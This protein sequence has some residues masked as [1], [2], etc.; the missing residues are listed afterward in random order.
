MINDLRQVRYTQRSSTIAGSDVYISPVSGKTTLS[1]T[2]ERHEVG[3]SFT[4]EQ[5]SL[6]V[7]GGK[8]PYTR[9]IDFR[10]SRDGLAQLIAH[11]QEGMTQKI[12]R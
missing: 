2:L 10:L 5:T 1:V 4:I 12:N 3:V 6:G 7:K 11:L 9:Q 8:R